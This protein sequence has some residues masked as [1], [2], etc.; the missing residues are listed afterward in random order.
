VYFVK[1]SLK[2][3]D[4]QDTEIKRTERKGTPSI[5]GASLQTGTLYAEKIRSAKTAK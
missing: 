3:S 5:P 4:N 1:T 2:K